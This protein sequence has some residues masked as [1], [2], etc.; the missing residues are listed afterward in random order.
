MI[1]EVVGAEIRLEALHGW[2][3][4]LAFYSP[5]KTTAWFLCKFSSYYMKHGL[6]FFPR[7]VLLTSCSWYLN[8]RSPIQMCPH[9]D[10]TQLRGPVERPGR[11]GLACGQWGVA[12]LFCR[13]HGGGLME[14]WVLCG[15]IYSLWDNLEIQMVLNFLIFKYVHTKQHNIWP[16]NRQFHNL[17]I[18][19]KLVGISAYEIVGAAFSLPYYLSHLLALLWHLPFPLAKRKETH[20]LS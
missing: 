8:F 18:K 15:H 9:G 13:G 19:R 17:C 6:E 1:V 4:T 16:M 11:S 12:C 10:V 3:S 7:A 14:V 20:F 2:W 5:I